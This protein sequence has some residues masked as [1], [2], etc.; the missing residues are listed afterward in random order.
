MRE[1]ESEKA[2]YSLRNIDK[3]LLFVAVVD[4]QR[5][6][7]RRLSAI[8]VSGARRLLGVR[9]GVLGLGSWGR[10]LRTQRGSKSER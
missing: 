6:G 8:V 2:I 4:K 3:L 1:S 5:V 7:S 9:S 10:V